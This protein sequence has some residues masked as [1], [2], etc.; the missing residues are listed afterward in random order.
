MIRL[1][2]ALEIPEEIKTKISEYKSEVINNNSELHWETPDKFHLTLKFL[3]DVEDELLKPVSGALEFLTNYERIECKLTR[4]GFF[5]KQ[6]VPKILWIGL[7]AD[8]ILFEIIEQ[9]NR[10][11]I[12]FSIPFEERKFKPHLTLLRIK[13]K[14]PEQ[15]V[16]KFKNFNIPET[17]F[18]A[19]NILLIQSE[20]LPGS[21][22]YTVVKKFNL[23]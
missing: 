10:E 1:F 3:G 9:L 7:W 18:T 6:G 14:F 12:K 20:L 22:K 17:I 23:K 8:K 2:V 16:T 15:W 11:L 4:F 21:S 19:G 13:D 5:F